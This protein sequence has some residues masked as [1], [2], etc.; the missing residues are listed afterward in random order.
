[1]SLS[2][3][4]PKMTCRNRVFALGVFMFLCAQLPAQNAKIVGGSHAEQGQFPW[5]ACMYLLG[6]PACGGVLVHPEWVLTAAH[7]LL[8]EDLEILSMRVNSIN[9]YGDLNPDGGAERNIAEV[10]IHPE[11]NF[12]ELVGQHVDLALFKL[13]EPITN[14]A[15]ITLPYGQDAAQIYESWS[16]V[17]LAGWGF[18]LV[19]GNNTNPDTLHWV[20][21][22]V[23]DFEMC[24][25]AV[26]NNISDDFFC[27]GY[28]EGQSPS[29]AASGDSG[30]PAWV[31]D[32]EDNAVLTGIV[33][34]ALWDYTGL[35][36][37]GVFVKV[38]E[39]LDW[40]EE[41]IGAAPVSTFNIDDHID[42][43]IASLPGKLE[44]RSDTY[45]GS[46]DVE[47]WSIH[48]LRLF[49]S[50]GEINPGSPISIGTDLLA[51][52]Y[53]IVHI[54]TLSGMAF[55]QKFILLH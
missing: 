3:F 7:C 30:G 1:M 54:K 47:I 46:L 9:A 15:P 24:E 21:S 38:A 35:D 36:E 44:I 42:F 23:Y 17:N 51:S 31:Y 22:N 5:M 19:N 50:K 16:P 11:Y 6:D 8:D 53:Y 32:Q 25:M 2:V 48:G 13:S 14:I 27:I 10:H 29:G 45:A 39:Q 55:S 34:G 52:G 28:T 4:H 20:T 26:G 33:H 40:I 43:G 37:P 12:D 49:T 18:V 41:V